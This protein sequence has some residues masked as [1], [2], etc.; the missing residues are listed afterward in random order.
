M[1][2][3]HLFSDEDKLKSFTGQFNPGRVLYL[4][5]NFTQPPKEKYLLVVSTNPIILMFVINSE[6]NPFKASKA[7]LLK[8]QLPV[9]ITEHDFLDHDSFID[10]SQVITQNDFRLEEIH[11][12][13]LKDMTRIKGTIT[14][15]LAQNI[16][17]VV[18]LSR[19]LV[20]DDIHSIINAFNN[21]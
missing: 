17:D 9:T 7:H 3:S 11:K 13:V 6:I 10:C 14:P 2:L 18:T 21:Y 8:A 5:C 16:L 20:K 15:L 12:Q 4:F 1:N 19:T